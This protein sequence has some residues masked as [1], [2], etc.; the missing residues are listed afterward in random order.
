MVDSFLDVYIA[1]KFKM[2]F[3]AAHKGEQGQVCK[4]RPIKVL[5]AFKGGS[6]TF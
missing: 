6:N 3:H 2:L 5:K 1:N 4:S